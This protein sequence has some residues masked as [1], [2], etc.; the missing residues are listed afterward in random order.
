[1]VES[2]N[3][4]DERYKITIIN[5]NRM[6]EKNKLTLKKLNNKAL[7]RVRI[8]FITATLKDIFFSGC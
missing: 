8:F 5:G 1:M 7:P 4:K 3:K 2:K 6:F